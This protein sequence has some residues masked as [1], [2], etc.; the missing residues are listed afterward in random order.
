MGFRLEIIGKIMGWIYLFFFTSIFIGASIIYILLMFQALPT[1]ENYAK[2]LN[3]IFKKF[4]T[5]NE[6]IPGFYIILSIIAII[7]S[8]PIIYVSHELIEG[9]KIV[10]IF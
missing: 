10:R 5:G 7:L 9:L 1:G 2:I 6:T 4:F 3:G 8:I